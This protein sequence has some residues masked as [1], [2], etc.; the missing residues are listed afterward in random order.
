MNKKL[1]VR[2]AFVCVILS[3]ML[4]VSC[5]KKK[6][7]TAPAAAAA[8]TPAAVTPAD[9]AANA[10][11]DTAKDEDAANVAADDNATKE[12]AGAAAAAGAETVNVTDIYFDY[13]SSDILSSETAALEAK[14]AWLKANPKAKITIEG[15]C[16]ERGT[17]E[18]NLALGDRRAA[19]TKGFLK[20][21]GI[22][23]DRMET[24]SYGEEKPAVVGHT[25]EAWSKNRRA[26][27]SGK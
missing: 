17:S 5:G 6:V 7:E 10:A 14:A 9:D 8:D 24:V 2:L 1:S 21:L 19:R 18:Y 4:V 23:A 3:L 20:K 13:D 15:H 25:E 22:S 27:F 16:D 12:T 26:H 11:A